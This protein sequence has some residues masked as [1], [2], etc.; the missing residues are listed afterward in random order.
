MKDALDDNGIAA[1]TALRLAHEVA[2]HAYMAENT[3]LGRKQEGHGAWQQA[4]AFADRLLQLDDS[5]AKANQQTAGLFHDTVIVAEGWARWVTEKLRFILAE[6]LPELADLLLLERRDQP[7]MAED[8]AAARLLADMVALAPADSVDQAGMAA[9]LTEVARGS[10]DV[11]PKALGLALLAAIEGTAGVE[12]CI[13]VTMQ[14]CDRDTEA[15]PDLLM[16]LHLVQVT[17]TED[18]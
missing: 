13:D 4:V 9:P 11:S 5:L 12:G 17:A 3:R 15:S 16:L 7:E 8:E 10:S 14:A 6:H 2:G 1:E 18:Y